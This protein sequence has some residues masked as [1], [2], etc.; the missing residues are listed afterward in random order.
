MQ[1]E[2]VSKRLRRSNMATPSF[3]RR[4]AAAALV[5]VAGGCSVASFPTLGQIELHT[6]GTGGGTVNVTRTLPGGCDGGGGTDPCV[7]QSGCTGGGEDA[8][9]CGMG[10]D[11]GF[12]VT[13]AAT[14]AQG[15]SFG[16]WTMTVTPPQ[17]V[18]TAMP[19]D[20]AATKQLTPQSPEKLY[21]LVDFALA[22]AG[23]D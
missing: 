23:L 11:P 5:L 1:N 18:A 6:T 15:A 22:D 8:Y 3:R 9:L 4:V 17:G 14:A 7:L 21:V 10:Y 19:L 20:V 2:S 13:F 12:P 16:G